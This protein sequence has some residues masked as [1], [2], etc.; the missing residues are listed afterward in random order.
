MFKSITAQPITHTTFKE[1]GMALAQYLIK[2]IS[3]K[4]KE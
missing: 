3:N 4:N 1:G 2:T